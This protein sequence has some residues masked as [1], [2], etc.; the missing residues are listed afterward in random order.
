MRSERKEKETQGKEMHLEDKN[1]GFATPY[2][3]LDL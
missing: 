2:G 1:I 3:E